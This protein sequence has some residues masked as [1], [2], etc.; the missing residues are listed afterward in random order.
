M[1][2]DV[3]I[4]GLSILVKSAFATWGKENGGGCKGL[5]QLS[6]LLFLK[7]DSYFS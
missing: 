2:V 5:K 4:D 3:D 6:R 1:V 7:S